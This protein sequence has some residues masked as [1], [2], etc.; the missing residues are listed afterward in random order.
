MVEEINRNAVFKPAIVYRTDIIGGV[1]Y[2]IHKMGVFEDFRQ[3]A[4]ICYFNIIPFL[5]KNLQNRSIIFCLTKYIQILGVP[6]NPRVV[7]KG[8]S[9]SNQERDSTFQKQF[10]HVLIKGRRNVHSYLFL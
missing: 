10:D 2:E 6:V 1:K 5:G 9:A 3:P 8:K 7:P 4:G